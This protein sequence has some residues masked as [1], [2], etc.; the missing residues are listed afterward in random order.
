MDVPVSR[1]TPPDVLRGLRDVHP[2]AE[3]VYAGQGR[4]LAGIVKP[5]SARRR[6]AI[7]LLQ[8]Q[9][10]RHVFVE[11]NHDQLLMGWLMLQGFGLVADYHIQGEPTGAI[12]EDF[13][14][15]DWV[16]RHLDMEQVYARLEAQ[17]EKLPEK[18]RAQLGVREKLQADGRW[19]FNRTVR[20]NPRPVAF[21]RT[22]TGV[23]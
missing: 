4:W 16:Y 1:E 8:M 5:D 20:K 2:Q 14:R 11:S 19:L 17:S 15:R 9:R 18:M 12:V 21:R 23:N 6:N 13:R 22:P 7:R 10:D 3:L